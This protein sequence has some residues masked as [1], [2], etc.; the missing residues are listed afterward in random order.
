MKHVSLSHF[1]TESDNY[2]VTCV[3]KPNGNLK[4]KD[5]LDHSILSKI[6]HYSNSFFGMFN[7][8]IY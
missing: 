5:I 4:K 2:A 6:K 7:L 1:F 3:I 8:Y